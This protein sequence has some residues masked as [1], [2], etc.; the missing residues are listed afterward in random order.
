MSLRQAIEAEREREMEPFRKKGMTPEP[1]IS[2]P[3]SAVL[4][5]RERGAAYITLS[6]LAKAFNDIK[7]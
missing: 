6:D 3:L 5:N 2:L 1:C 4:I 7:S